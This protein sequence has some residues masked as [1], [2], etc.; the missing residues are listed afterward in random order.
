MTTGPEGTTGTSRRA[1]WLTERQLPAYP[2]AGWRFFYLGVVIV[3][4]IV[5]WYQYYVPTSVAPLILQTVHLSFRSYVSI[6]VGSNLAGV[7]A[8]LAGGITDRIGRTWVVIG[9]LLVVALIQLVAVPNTTTAAPLVVELV[10]VGLFEGIILVATPALVRDFTPQLGRASAMGFW[11]L[12]PVAG[13]LV[14][15]LLGSHTLSAT[16]LDWHREFLISGVVGLV[17]FVVALLF[18]RE[19][20][21][22]IR[23]QVMVTQRDRELI[24]LQARGLDATTATE[25][26]WR[27]MLRLD[28]VVSALA[29]SLM[30]IIFYTASGFFTVYFATVFHHGT[31]YFTLPQANGIDTWIWGADCIG[32]I[33][34]G[35]LSDLTR[36]RKPFMLVGGIGAMVMMVV[37]I[38]HTGHP[39]SSYGT[40]VWVTS[41]L[42]LFTAMAYA[43]WMASFTETVEDRNPA[44]VATGLA[45]W[46]GILR[47]VVAASLFTLPFV[48]SAANRVVDNQRYE[49]YVPRAL[50]I[51]HRYG[52]LVAIVQRHQALFTKLASY[53]DAATAPKLLLFEAL[54]AV[55]GKVATL[56]KIAAIKPQLAFLQHYQ[57]HLLA[58]QSGT[59]A[60]PAQWQHWFWVCF[61]GIAV[62]TPLIFVLKGRWSPSRARQDEAE[63][64]A[65]V[66]AELARLRAEAGTAADAA[67]EPVSR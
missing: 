7:V 66:A 23:D 49:K 50:A 44:L 27:Q 64:E 59:A 26:P 20:S 30:L 21:P 25:H 60:S 47:F 24:E 53:P 8:A 34:F 63:H 16:S 46:G 37:L 19:L 51:E 33:V 13:V 54:A 36:V 4:S 12:G 41:V 18:L 14:A 38:S 55:H 45:I 67:A 56:L 48:V 9:G 2:S 35:V 15:S 10:A 43:T 42:F 58:L 57:S 6:I 3:A 5:L 31:T 62:F 40:M 52:P 61:A 28:V 1:R 11:T 32:L 17:V 22:Q 39:T 29:V 65:V